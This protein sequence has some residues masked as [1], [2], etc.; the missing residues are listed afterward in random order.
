MEA[1]EPDLT[2]IKYHDGIPL[3]IFVYPRM[4]TIIIIIIIIIIISIQKF[5]EDDSLK[6]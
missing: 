5:F 2:V 6:I 3:G 1:A 4:L